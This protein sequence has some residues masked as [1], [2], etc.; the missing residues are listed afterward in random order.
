MKNFQQ[1]PLSQCAFNLEE[2]R[3]DIWQYP[4]HTTFNEARFLLNKEE[5]DR[6]ERF[7]FERH[8]RRFTV[9]RATLK[10]ILAR[11]LLIQPQEINFTYTEHGK[12][13]LRNDSALQFNISHSGEMALLAIGQRYPLG[14]DVEFFSDRPFEGIAKNLFSPQEILVLQ[15]ADLKMKPLV[16][17]H[18]W[19][20]KEALIKACG[21]G[22]TY[23]TQKFD[24]SVFQNKK[25]VID[26]LHEKKWQMRY[27]MPQMACSA[28]LCSDP[29]ID[30]I[31]YFNIKDVGELF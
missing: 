20:Q 8:Q 21:L 15:Q 4:L 17:F 16:F 28:A 7:Y 30:K 22:L 25:E 18:I 24:V 5:I 12:P 14:I 6:A 9:A 31:H 26:Y 2:T 3:I 19:A 11:Y 10:I 23:P 29:L 27:F 13:E 1:L